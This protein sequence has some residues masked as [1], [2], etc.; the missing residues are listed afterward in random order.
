MVARLL[1]II[2]ISGLLISCH[3]T[4]NLT[5]P[6]LSHTRDINI[7]VQQVYLDNLDQVHIVDTRGTLTRYDEQLNAQYIYAD[8][9]LGTIDHID[10]TNPLT[11]LVYHRQYG[12]ISYLDNTLAK[13]KKQN[14]QDWGYFD[15]N[16][17]ASSN[18]GNIWLYDPIKNQILKID[19]TGKELLSS[20][21]LNDYNLNNLTP[22]KIIEREN[23][24]FIYDQ[25]YGI[26]VFDNL[27][28]YLKILPLKNIVNFQTDGK[29]I[30]CYDKNIM[31]SYSIKLMDQ[32]EIE[33][34]PTSTPK[35]IIIS[36]NWIYY[37]YE[38]GVDRV[39]RIY[40]K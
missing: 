7:S 29:F 38:D 22:I 13:I 27:G 11:V 14:I 1:I 20:H 35:N 34:N 8:L 5:S 28:Q 16:T 19:D 26:I 18:D 32:N 3:T 9:T 21:N 24:L 37:I 15:V 10:V 4:Q 2:A 6:I 33:I 40:A 39:A 12:V 30:Y 36:T 31:M 25:Q 17:I 23:L